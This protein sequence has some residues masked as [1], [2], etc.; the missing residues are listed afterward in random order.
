M[1]AH[2]YPHRK[3]TTFIFL[4]LASMWLTHRGNGNAARADEPPKPP[5]ADITVSVDD[6]KKDFAADEAAAKAKYDGKI[7]R[8]TGTLKTVADYDVDYNYAF[9][10]DG[11]PAINCVASKSGSKGAKAIS[12]GQEATVQGKC[13]TATKDSFALSACQ[14]ISTGKDPSTKVAA[15]DLAKAYATKGHPADYEGA[16]VTIDGTVASVDVDS[17]KV[18]LVGYTGADGKPVNIK[19]PLG[20]SFEDSLK[21]LTKGSKVVVK[22]TC[23]GMMDGDDVV[24]QFAV[25]QE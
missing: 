23:N 18:F 1:H 21:K 9:T 14:V 24:I 8:V 20:P 19:C 4:T 12:I 2:L 10:L 25:L 3:T 5:D 11:M 15:A 16:T 22:G 17:F 6:I 13:T 7:V